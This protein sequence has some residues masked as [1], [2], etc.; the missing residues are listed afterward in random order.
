M[1]EPQKIPINQIHVSAAR[2]K[3]LHPPTVRLI[4]ESIVKN[5]LQTPIQVTHD[6]KRYVLVEGLH[7]LE[8][9]KW[10]GETTV[11]SYLVE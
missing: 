5:G 8:A 7:R 3:T 11:D 10:L 9:L 4:A 2:R 1:P 6:G